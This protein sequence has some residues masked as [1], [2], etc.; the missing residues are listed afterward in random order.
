MW[1]PEVK[2]NDGFTISWDYDNADLKCVWKC[3]DKKQLFSHWTQSI[4]SVSNS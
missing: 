4:V 3:M 1:Q 2:Q